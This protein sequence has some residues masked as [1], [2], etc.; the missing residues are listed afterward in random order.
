MTGWRIGYIA[1]PDEL[2]KSAVKIQQ[3]LLLSICSFAQ[4]GAVAALEGPQ[5]CVA[6]MVNEFSKRREVILNGIAIN[7]FHNQHSIYR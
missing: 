4:A 2:I 5:D 6:E 1:A 7:R 3:N